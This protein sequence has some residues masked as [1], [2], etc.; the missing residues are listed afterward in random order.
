M[1]VTSFAATGNFLTDAD[2]RNWGQGISN[3]LAAVGL[4]KTAD[5]GQINWTT[6][7]KPAGTGVIS[8][9]EMWRFNDA[10]QATAPV[11]IKIEYGSGGSAAGAHGLWITVATA[12]DGAGNLTGA[13]LGTRKQ[14]GNQSTH[15]GATIYVSGATDRIGL[16][17][18]MSTPT[19]GYG[20][21]V[22]RSKDAS[23]NNTSAGICTYISSAFSSYSS[24]EQFIPSVGIVPT[25]EIQPY[26]FAARLTPLFLVQMW[27][28]FL[29]LST[30]VNC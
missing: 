17:V 27:V 10:L 8:G 30:S 28:Y 23:G 19:Y 3:A 25:A 1:S 12:T 22:E 21:H 2:F 24:Q 15:A 18:V 5:T 11:F 9:Y 29:T 20:F 16:A 14:T 6:V 4:V 26:A 13:Q 7:V